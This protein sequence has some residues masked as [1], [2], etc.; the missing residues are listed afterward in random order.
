MV[1]NPIAQNQTE[2]KLN[3]WLV[4]FSYKTPV[5][6][7]SRTDGKAY[8]TSKYWS[9]TTSR[10]V[11]NYLKERGRYPLGSSEVEKK[12]QSFFDSLVK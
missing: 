7:I 1:L 9:K 2:L 5:V 4:F 12:D 10:H 11:N 8:Q 3:D 6:A